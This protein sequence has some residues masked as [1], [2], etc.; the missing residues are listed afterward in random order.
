MESIIGPM[1]ASPSTDAQCGCREE[2]VKDAANTNATVFLTIATCYVQIL[3][4]IQALSTKLCE[5]VRSNNQG[6]T[7]RSLTCIRIGS[8][9]TSLANPAIQAS[10]I[11]QLLSQLP[12]EIQKKVAQLS[13]VTMGYS[14]QLQ[15]RR[16]AGSSFSQILLAMYIVTLWI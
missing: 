16:G 11:A 7:L 5:I 15:I 6:S 13:C 4:N 9:G 8:C 3:Q 10:I 14:T 12:R 2:K 1:L